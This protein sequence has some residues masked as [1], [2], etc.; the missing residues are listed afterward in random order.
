MYLDQFR[1]PFSDRYFTV[2]IPKI[3]RLRRAFQFPRTSNRDF[4]TEPPKNFRLRRAFLR[5]LILEFHPP[6]V[7]DNPKIAAND[8]EKRTPPLVTPTLVEGCVRYA[9]V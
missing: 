5:E 2:T 4:T 1:K 7:E 3:S 9:V 6:L 8:L